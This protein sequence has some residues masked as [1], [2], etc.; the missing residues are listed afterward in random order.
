MLQVKRLSKRFGGLIALDQLDMDIPDS[1]I[2]GVIGPNGAGKTT[3][4]NAVSGF[5]SPTSG[6][7]IFDGQ[8]IT[9]LRADEIAQRGISRTFQ[10]ATL[11]TGLSVL[12]NVFVGCHM[13]YE[14]KIWRRLFRM[15]S[16]LEEERTL[17]EKTKEIIDFM[18]LGSL[19]DEIAKN[20]P[21]GH[22]KILSVCIALATQPKLLLLDEPVT[23]MNSTEIQ[24]M[25]DL[26]QRIRNSGVTIAI[27]EHNMRTVMNLCDRLIVL[28]YGK[29]IAE[30]LPREILKNEEVI[31][32]YLG[33]KEAQGDAA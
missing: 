33:E 20:L 13:R 28:N 30:G 12:E 7:V 27:V 21:H 4:F 24:A 1:E 10:A 6:Q 32:A 25:T 8:D 29:K 14:T 3:L 18:G 19:K 16:A 2:L 31:E 9:G 5:F 26:I 11:F 17:K 23:G 22:Q 15:P